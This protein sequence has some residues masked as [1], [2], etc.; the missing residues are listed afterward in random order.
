MRKKKEEIR[1]K[2]LPRPNFKEIVVSP[3]LNACIS[4]L[5]GTQ[6]QFC[7]TCE[8]MNDIKSF[9]SCNISLT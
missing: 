4:F 9:S 7:P 1:H 8:K 6:L 5:V 3:Q 2:H